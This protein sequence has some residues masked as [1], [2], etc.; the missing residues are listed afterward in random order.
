LDRRRAPEKLPKKDQKL[1]EHAKG[2]RVFLIPA[3]LEAHRESR[4]WRDKKQG[5]LFF[6]FVFL[7]KQRK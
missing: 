3:D 6:W 4:Q 2:G 5:C 1:S 7:D